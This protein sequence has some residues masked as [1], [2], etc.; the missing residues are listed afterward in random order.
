MYWKNKTIAA[1][2]GNTHCD[3]ILQLVKMNQTKDFIET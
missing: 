2:L 3:N 1:I